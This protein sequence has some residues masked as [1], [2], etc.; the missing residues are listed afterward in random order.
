MNDNISH[1]FITGWVNGEPY[2]HSVRVPAPGSAECFQAFFRAE[3]EKS[4]ATTRV[5]CASAAG[6]KNTNHSI[7]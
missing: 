3:R 1:N 6:N 5:T 7:F 2:R 4:E